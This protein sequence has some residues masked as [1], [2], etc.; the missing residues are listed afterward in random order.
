MTD[1]ILRRREVEARTGLPRSTMY[2]EIAGGRFP[3]Q[4]KLGVRA[5]GWSE[6]EIAAWL[7]NRKSSRKDG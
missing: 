1:R 6:A 7:D 4:I 5:V 3:P 2:A